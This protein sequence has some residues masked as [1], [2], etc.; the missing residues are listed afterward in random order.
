MAKVTRNGK[1]KTQ[2]F[3]MRQIKNAENTAKTKVPVQ[4][5]ELQNS[6]STDKIEDWSVYLFSDKDY[7]PHVEFGT[8]DQR[9]QPFLR[10]AVRRLNRR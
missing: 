8:K 2:N 3:L 5:G 1:K 4:T 9:P 6:I 7:A 10:P